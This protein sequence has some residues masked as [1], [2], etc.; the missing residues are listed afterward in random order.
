MV[1]RLEQLQLSG[2]TIQADNSNASV[3]TA[4]GMATSSFP[5]THAL[6]NVS[7]KYLKTDQKWST[8]CSL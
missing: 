2:Q 7:L 6:N 3:L 4:L 5:T 8:K 1:D